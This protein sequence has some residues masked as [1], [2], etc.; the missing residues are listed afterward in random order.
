MPRYQEGIGRRRRDDEYRFGWR[1]DEREPRSFRDYGEPVD[2]GRRSAQGGPA[3]GGRY[4]DRYGR[5]MDEPRYVDERPRYGAMDRSYD[6]EGRLRQR[7]GERFEDR[8]EEEDRGEMRYDRDD[9]RYERMDRDE[10]YD[11]DRDH[12]SI[13][14]DDRAGRVWRASRGRGAMDQGRMY[15]RSREYNLYGRDRDRDRD[16]YMDDRDRYLRERERER[17]EPYYGRR[18]GMSRGPWR[19][20]RGYGMGH[21]YGMDDPRERRGMYGR[22][23]PREYEERRERWPYRPGRSRM[24]GR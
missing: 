7:R 21:G 23:E 8:F 6:D 20:T 24:G 1:D 9:D 3:Y 18:E 2:R 16:R 12:F 22:D 4:D 11:R 13:D 5:R 10:V 19:D 17:R 15:D 14:E